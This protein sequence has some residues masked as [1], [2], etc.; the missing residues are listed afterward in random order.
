MRFEGKND[1]LRLAI[2][3]SGSHGGLG[4]ADV[5]RDFKVS[6]R[7]AQRMMAAIRDRFS[8][9]EEV[10][11]VADDRAKRWRLPQKAL[12]GL[13]GAEPIELAELERAARRLREEGAA[14]GRAEA[15]ERL[16][17]KLRA[18]MKAADRLRMEPDVEAMMQAEGT[19][20]RPGPRPVVPAALL[21]AIRHALLAS[22]RMR[23]LYGA[24]PADPRERV[25]E[26]LGLLHGLRPYLVAQIVGYPQG[27]SVF[28]LDRIREHA[29]LPDPFVPNPG[30][31]LQAYT[32][33]SFGVWQEEPFAVCL[34]FSDAAAEEAGTYHFHSTQTLEHRPD[35]SLLVRFTAGGR[36]EMC[37]HLVTWEDRV[38]VL[39]PAGLRQHLADWARGVAEH[40]ARTPLPEEGNA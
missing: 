12:G 8:G 20:I 37:Q 26:P 24:D 29:V 36:L 10:E 35:G 13:M 14:A 30:F 27:A 40:H 28:R 2:L 21:G 34:R 16:A 25:V 32:Q 17:A 31:S 4:I 23:L 3:L 38:E 15:L 33:R 22:R 9:C 11:G 6:H 7:T 39:E 1:L 5:Q 19:A 18:A